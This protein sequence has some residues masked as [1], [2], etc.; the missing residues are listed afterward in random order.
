MWDA[1]MHAF[2]AVR[3][4]DVFSGVAF[5][6]MLTASIA[7]IFY[8]LKDMPFKVWRLFVKMI[9]VK[10]ELTSDQAEFVSFRLWLQ[11]FNQKNLRSYALYSEIA[12]KNVYPFSQSE[13]VFYLQPGTGG[14]LL[15]Y[16]H[17]PIYIYK[18]I[19]MQNTQGVIENIRLTTIGIRSTFINSIVQ[20][21]VNIS[22]R[23][24]KLKIFNTDG[25]YW[26]TSYK[27]KKCTEYFVYSRKNELIETVRSFYEKQDWY[28]D[29]GLA[30]KM[31]I[32]LYG[33]PGTGKSTLISVIA[34][35]LNLAVYYLN[36]S[37]QTVV[38][39]LISLVSKIG[40]N[41]IIL[42]EDID[43]MNLTKDRRKE[44]DATNSEHLST[45]LNVL[46]GVNSSNGVIY[47]LTTNYID[48]IDKAL[49]R[50]GR[51]HLQIEMKNFGYDQIKEMFN[52]FY[53]PDQFDRF[54]N[55]FRNEAGDDVSPAAL[56]NLFIR[57]DDV[58]SLLDFLMNNPDQ[59]VNN[60]LEYHD[61]CTI[62]QIVDNSLIEL[63]VQ[64]MPVQ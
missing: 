32:L 40:P 31:G 2:E 18:S 26:D 30:H 11:R 20:E 54:Y 14:H 4:N 53:D 50:P 58:E 19:S 36:L 17:R 61:E 9:T 56:Q 43:C 3:H 15:W 62:P 23:T 64:N 35:E 24:E 49:I 55:V 27:D 1:V 34:S 59:I 7:G 44:S 8:S 13:N 46:D 37:D 33:K 63:E 21:V 29:R 42:I 51:I 16:K 60:Y 22:N 10:L 39:D 38:R 48:R 57:F 47:F 28:R 5:G 41:S 45:L 12:E 25:S 52:L 6:S